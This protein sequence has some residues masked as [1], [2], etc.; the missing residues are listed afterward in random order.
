MKRAFL[1]FF[2]ISLFITIHLSA[3]QLTEIKL[4]FSTQVGLTRIV[5]EGN[6]ACIENT[7]VTPQASQI[8][9]KFPEPIKLNPQKNPPFGIS[10]KD[11]ILILLGLIES[12]LRVFNL[13]FP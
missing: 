3:Q 12:T 13:Y 1:L 4:R 2:F 9:I 7:K 6:E 11:N 5:L 8:K 10:L